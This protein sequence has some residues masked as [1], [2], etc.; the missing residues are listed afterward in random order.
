MKTLFAFSVLSILVGV[1]AAVT[2]DAPSRA[3]PGQDR[4]AG[5]SDPHIVPPRATPGLR[6][7][8]APAL[9]YHFVSQP[10]PMPGQKFGNVAGVALTPE[11]HLL[12]FNRNPA[13][14]MVEYDAQGKFQGHNTNFSRCAL[15]QIACFSSGQNTPSQPFR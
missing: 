12:A 13:M 6:P 8:G 2:Q 5:R 9:P 7:P 4:P 1:T 10:A 11:G 14:M 3:Q 15:K